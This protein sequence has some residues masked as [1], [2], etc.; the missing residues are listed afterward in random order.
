MLLNERQRDAL[1]ELINIAFAR[2]GAALSDLTGNRVLLAAPEVAIHPTGELRPALARFVPGEAAWI[3]QLFAGPI[4]GDALLLLT[5]ESAVELS[6]LLG[7]GRSSA[8]RLDES[9]RE[10]LTEV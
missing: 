9:A 10:A 2:T 6:N 7:D 5:Y 3:H 8:K 1:A 4:G